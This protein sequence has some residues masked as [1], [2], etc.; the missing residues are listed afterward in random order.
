MPLAGWTV[1]CGLDWTVD[2]EGVN[3]GLNAI[4][5]DACASHTLGA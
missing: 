1:D 4:D 3:L 5:N 2:G